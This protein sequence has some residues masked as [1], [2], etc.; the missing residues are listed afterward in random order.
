MIKLEDAFSNEDGI[1]ITKRGNIA[2]IYFWGQTHLFI[3]K[4]TYEI[5]GKERFEAIVIKVF[6]IER[7]IK[8]R[9]DVREEFGLLE[10]GFVPEWDLYQ[11][12]VP[13]LRELEKLEIDPEKKIP[14]L[15]AL[16]NKYL[17]E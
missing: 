2:T 14:Q 3:P 4:K 8:F 17:G 6:G 12:A 10:G 16:I 13:S 11:I 5:L 1:E 15:V 7:L 9:G